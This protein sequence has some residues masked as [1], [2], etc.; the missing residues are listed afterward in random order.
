M[1]DQEQCPSNDGAE[2]PE[3]STDCPAKELDLNNVILTDMVEK[4][5]SMIDA[6]RLAWRERRVL[7]ENFLLHVEARKQRLDQLAKIVK[8]HVD[9]PFWLDFRS[10]MLSGS[11]EF[12]EPR[13]AACDGAGAGTFHQ[14]S[15]SLASSAFEVPELEITRI[16][17]GDTFFESELN[18]GTNFATPPEKPL[19]CMNS[20]KFDSTF[21]ANPH[22]RTASG[23]DHNALCL[24]LVDDLLRINESGV[25]VAG[26]DAAGS[27]SFWSEILGRVTYAIAPDEAV[28]ADSRDFLALPQESTA[29]D[30]GV[31]SCLFPDK[32]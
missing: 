23:S 9:E 31:S 14:A 20:S 17:A 2:Q 4:V 12:D 5:R 18:Q 22:P 11:G 30:S 32:S 7:E 26:L 8:P 29:R 3:R 19:G 15:I 6:R 28:S 21:T 1:L 10:S 24:K 16:E 13:N 27:R 25:P